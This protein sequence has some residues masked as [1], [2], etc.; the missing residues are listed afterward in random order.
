LIINENNW[1][2]EVDKTLSNSNDTLQPIFIKLYLA[3]YDNSDVYEYRLLI[4]FK[5][6]E[7]S[8][9]QLKEQEKIEEEKR[10]EA[11]R[12]L[13]EQKQ[14]EAEERAVKEEAERPMRELREKVRTGCLASN[15]FK[16]KAYG[17][18]SYFVQK[19]RIMDYI[20][21]SDPQYTG[22]GNWY[23]MRGTMS[24]TYKETNSLWEDYTLTVACLYE[25]DT[26]ESISYTWDDGDS[27]EEMQKLEA[28]IIEKMAIEKGFKTRQKQNT[29]DGICKDGTA[30][31]GN[32]HAKGAA[33]SCYGHGGWR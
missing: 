12:I 13:A 30:A 6:N 26:S 5:I 24:I 7:N 21:V 8:I 19:N 3:N 10:A 32:R 27:E 20:N 11:A 25:I 9:S 29:S 16:N 28:E 1:S 18:F 31:F 2:F 17:D 4:N 14:K 22:Y 15:S 33:N 23:L